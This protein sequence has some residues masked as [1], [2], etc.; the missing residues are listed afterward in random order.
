MYWE[1]EHIEWNKYIWTYNE[2]GGFEKEFTY[3]FDT[4]SWDMPYF[5]SP[6]ETDVENI[7]YEDLWS[8]IIE[9]S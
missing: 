9:K 8:L 4:Q 7:F 6:K 3:D 1:F 5:D 2:F